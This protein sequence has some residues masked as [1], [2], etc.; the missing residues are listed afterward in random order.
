MISQIKRLVTLILLFSTFCSV[1]GQTYVLNGTTNGTTINTCG[2]TF[3]DSGINS[4]YSNNE[5]FSI[6]FCSNA[7]QSIELDFSSFDIENQ[8]SCS[9]DVLEIYD[10]LN[11]SSSLLGSYCGTSVP[12][13]IVST[14]DCLHVTFSSNASVNAAGWFANIICGNTD[15][16]CGN[17]IDDDGDGSIDEHCNSCPTGSISY[18]RWS[19]ITG[20][21]VSSLTNHP[22]YPNNPSHSG[23][24]SLFQGPNNI[25]NNFGTRVRG[26]LKPT[27]TGWYDFTVTSDDSSEFYIS[28]DGDPNNKVLVASVPGWTYVTEFDKYP[29]Q[30]SAAIYLYAGA[31]YYVEMLHKE[32]IGGDHLQVYWTTPSSSTNTIIPGSVLST[33]DC[34][35]PQQAVNLSLPQTQYF[36]DDS[37]PTLNGGSPA[38]GTYSG[39]GVTGN[40]LNLSTAGEGIH[41]ITYSYT[42][43]SGCEN[44]D[45]D[46]IEILDLTSYAYEVCNNGIDD[47]GDGSIDEDC[48]DCEAGSI[49]YE[50][51]LGISGVSISDLTSNA[52]YPNNPSESGVFTS[53]NGPIGYGGN[54]GTRVRGYLEPQETGYYTFT[55]TSDDRSELYLSSDGDPNN[56]SVIASVPGWSN[57]T[58][59]NKYP[60]Q[61]SAAIYLYAGAHY[62]IEMLH[63]E[64]GGGDHL[65]TYW[66]TPSNSTRTII[67]GSF[68]HP[69]E[70]CFIDAGSDATICLGSSVGLT[71]TPDGSGSFS[72]N[73]SPAAGLSSTSVQNPTASPTS[74]TIYTVTVTD[75]TGC[76]ATDE[77]E[78]TVLNGPIVTVPNENIC[79]GETSNITPTATGASPFTFDWGGATTSG[80]TLTVSPLITTIYTV[81]VT[82]NNSCTSTASTTINVEQLPNV[83]LNIPDLE[84]CIDDMNVT[85]SGGSPSGGTYSIDGVIGNILDVN[86][87]GL[88]VHTIGYTYT[89]GNGCTNSASQVININDVPSVELSLAINESCVDAS[90]IELS[91]GTPSGGIYSGPGVTGT[92]FDIST[93]GVGIHTI[94]YTYE[95]GNGC[96]DTATD[97]I[98][99]YDLPTVDLVFSTTEFCVSETTF[100]LSEGTPMGGSYNG[101][102]VIGSNFD[103]GLAGIGTHIIEYELTDGNGCINSASQ[104]IEVYGLP[105][106]TFDLGISE[107]CVN[108]MDINLTGGSP[109]GGTYSGPGVN[110]STFS[111]SVAGLGLHTLTYTYSD[112]NNCEETGTHQIFVND[113]TAV[114]LDLPINESCIE[115]SSIDL[116]DGMPSGGTYSGPGVTGTSFDI[117]TAGEGI[118]TIVYTYEDGNGCINT[119]TDQIEIYDLPSVE[120][121][122][123]NTDDCISESIFA[124]SGGTPIGGT[125]SGPGVTGTNFNASLAGLGTHTIQYEFID[126]NGCEDSAIQE[127][128]VHELPSVAFEI[129]QKEICLNSVSIEIS[130]GTP[131]GGTYSGTAVNGNLFSP[132]N[133]GLGT[134][135]ITYT[136][137]DAFGCQNSLDQ[138]IEV[139]N[140]P[141]VSM[142]IGKYT[143]CVDEDP[144]TLLGE[145]PSGGMYTGPG[146][147][148]NVFDPQSAG[149][150]IHTIRYE[151]TGTNNCINS[152]TEEI[153]VYDLPPVTL[154]FADPNLCVQSDMFELNEGTPSGGSYS[155]IGVNGTNFDASS[156]G[157]GTYEVTYSYSD[158]NGCVNQDSDF[159]VV[160]NTTDL[161]FELTNN[162]VCQEETA[163]ALTEASPTGGNYSGPGVTAN[164]FSPSDAGVGLHTIIYTYDDGSCINEISDEIEVLSTPTVTLDL[165]VIEACYGEDKITISGGFPSGGTY[166]GPGILGITLS[167]YD[168]GI[169]VHEFSYTYTNSDGCTGVATQL[170]TVHALPS[171][172]LNLS[173]DEACI[174]ETIHTLDGMSPAGGTF[175]GPGVTGTNFDASSVGVGSHEITYSYTDS[176]GCV[177]EATDIIVVSNPKELTFELTE[178]QICQ[179]ASAI[180]LSEANPA[181]GTYSGPGVIGNNFNPAD[182]GVGVHTITYTYDDGVCVSVITDEIEV[183]PTPLVTID[184]DINQAC[185]GE[186]NIILSGGLPAGGTYSGNGISD[187]SLNTFDSGA[188]TF[189]VTYTYTSPDGCMDSATQPFTVH[190]LPTVTLNL[191][192]DLACVTETVHMLDGMSPS[193]GTFSGPGV[194]GTNFDATIAGSGDHEIV[195]AYIDQFGC[196]NTATDII[197]VVDLPNPTLILPAETICEGEILSLSGGEPAGGEWTGPG[198]VGDEFDASI[199]G[200]GTHTINYTFTISECYIFA[201]DQI[202][203]YPLPTVTVSLSQTAFCF[204]ETFVLDG[205]SPLGGIWSGPGVVGGI[206]DSALA[207]VGTH[208]VVYSFTSNDGCSIETT[209]ELTVYQETVVDL[210][211]GQDVDCADNN[212]L[213]LSGGFPL[214]GV[215][216]GP[217]VSGNNFDASTAGE[218]IHSISYSFTDA[219]GCTN[220]AFDQ[221]TVNPLPDVTLDLLSDEACPDE[222]TV[223][224]SGGWPLGGTYSGPGVVGNT[225]D[226]GLAGEGVH[227]I[228]YTV[229]TN[230]CTD[231]ATDD[232]EV[233]PAYDE[234]FA[235]DVDGVCI[236]FD[237]ELS[238]NAPLGGLYSGPG[239]NPFNGDFLSVVAGIGTHTINYNFIDANGCEV[240]LSDELTV[241]D[242]PPASLSIENN[243]LCATEVNVA[244]TGGTP[245]GGTY[246]G[247]GVTGN[248]F[249][250]LSVGA[251]SYTITYSY[252]DSNGCQAEAIDE[253]VVDP[254]PS[255]TFTYTDDH[256]NLSSGSVSF[257]FQDQANISQIQFSLNGGTNW[258][259]PIS[260]ASGGITYA[261]LSAGTYNLMVRNEGGTCETDLGQIVIENIDGPTAD[262]GPDVTI[263]AFDNTQLTGAGGSFYIWSP[264]TGLNNTNISDPIASPT[265]TTTYTLQVTDIF[266]CTDTD[267]VTVFVETTCAGTITD[268]DYPYTESFESGLG[269]WS[270]ETQDDFDWL[271]NNGSIA[272]G[273]SASQ[274]TWYMMA[275]EDNTTSQTAIFRSPCFDLMDQS[276]AQ[277]TFDYYLANGGSLSLQATNEYGTNWTTIWS[278][279][280]N[281]GF[282]W[283]TQIVDLFAYLNT[284]LQLRFV[285]DMGSSSGGSMGVDNV[286]FITTGCGCDDT[287][288]PF[289]NFNLVSDPQPF[290]VDIDCDGDADMLSGG[291]EQLFFFENNG[292]GTYTDQTGTGQDIMPNLNFLDMTIGLVDLDNDGDKDMSIVGNEAFNKFFFWNTGTK[293]NPI[294]TQAGTGGTPANPIAGFDFSSLDG[295]VWI[296]YADPTIYWADL[297]NDDDYDAVVGGKLGWF[298][299]YENIGD[300]MTPNLVA[301]T[302]GANPFNGLRVDGADEGNGLIQYESSPFL[303]DWD[304]DGDLDLFS[305]NQI[306][307]VQYFENIGS[308]TNPIFVERSGSANPFDGVIFSEDS[309]LSIIDEDCDGDWDVFY[310]VGDSPADAE[311]TICD[312]LVAVPNFA[313]AS[314]NQSHFC[315]GESIFLSEESTVGVTWNWTGPDGFTSTEQNPVLNDAADEMVGTYTVTITNEQ[316]CEFTST[317]DIT[318]SGSTA[319]AGPDS[320][321]DQGESTQNQGSGDGNTYIWSPATGLDD[322][323]VLNPTANPT[324]TTTYTLTVIDQFGCASTDQMTVYVTSAACTYKNQLFFADFENTIGDNF[325]TIQNNATDG[326]FI[327]GEPSP[328]TQS[329]LTVMELNPQEGDQSMITGNATNYTQDLDGGPSTA[330]SSNFDLPN[331]AT[332]VTLEMYWYFSHFINGDAA[333]FLTIE[334]RDA[335]NN[336]VLQTLVDET[337]SP[338][339]RDAVWTLLNADLSSHAGKTVYLYVRASDAGNGSKVEVGIDNILVTGTFSTIADIELTQKDFCDTDSPYVLSGGT[340]EGGTYVGTG[341]TGNIFDP[342]AAGPGTHT[343]TYEYSDIGGCIAQAAAWIEVSEPPLTELELVID[344]VCVNQAAVGL[345]GGLPTG[346]EWSGTSVIGSTFYPPVAGVGAHDITYTVTDANGCSNS[347]TAEIYVL[348]VPIVKGISSTDAFCGLDNGTITIS[349]DDVV[350]IDSIE[351]SLDGGFTWQDAVADTDGDV[352]Y[353]DLPF[354]SYDLWVR[355]ANENCPSQM[356]LT[357]I[358][359]ILPPLV[360]VGTDLDFCVGDSRT[361]NP[362]V[363]AGTSP[364]TYS[365]SG[366]NGFASDQI[367]VEL[368]DEGVYALVVTDDNNCT[369]TDSLTISNFSLSIDA[370]IVPVACFGDDNGRILASA[371]G[372]PPYTYTLIGEG[373][374]GSGV[375][376]NLTQGFYTLQVQDGSG[377]VST[378]GFNVPG[379]PPLTCSQDSCVRNTSVSWSG[380]DNGPWTTSIGTTNVSLSVTNESNTTVSTFALDGSITNSNP[381]WFVESAAGTPALTITPNWDTAPED[382]MTDIDVATDDKGVMTFTFTFDNAISDIVLHV[383][384]LGEFA[385]NGTTTRSNSSQWTITT[386]GV[387]LYKLSGTADLEV[388]GNAFFRSYDVEHDMGADAAASTAEGSAAGSIAVFASTPLSSITFEVTGV[389]LEGQAQDE[390]LLAISGSEC[391]P[392]TPTNFNCDSAPGAATISAHGGVQP[393]TYQWENGETTQT[394]TNLSGGTHAVSITDANGCVQVCSVT[395]EEDIIDVSAGMNISFCAD[396]SGILTPNV[397]GGTGPY[398]YAW[399]GPNGFTYADENPTVTEGGAYD[400]IVTDN[401]GC[402]GMDQVIVYAFA[403]EETSNCYYL[404]EFNNFSYFGSDGTLDWSSFGWDET[405]DNNSAISGD[406]MISD[407]EGTL[408]MQNTNNTDPSIERQVDLGGHSSAILSFDYSTEGSLVGGDVFVVEVFDGTSWNTVFS[409]I[410][411]L[412]GVQKPWLDITD[413]ISADAAIR[414]SIES[415]YNQ[416]S[417]KLIIDNVRIDLDCLCEGNS[418]AGIDLEICAGDT[419]Q[420]MGIGDGDFVWS[421]A[422]TLSDATV[423]EPLAFPTETTTYQ[424][425]VTD[426]YGCEDTSEVTITVNESIAANITPETADYCYDGSGSALLDISEGTGP[427]SVSWTDEDGTPVGSLEVPNLGTVEILGLFGGVTYCFQILDANGCVVQSP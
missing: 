173:D 28:S 209:H 47:D 346:G 271:R 153:E 350:D 191:T 120:L 99:I 334:L 140:L 144:Y 420:L 275:D 93:A 122:L 290:S 244:L 300:E 250:P 257:V 145:T 5:N 422:T 385:T 278:E 51:W 246:S 85:L 80:N 331:L 160:S 174:T 342:V 248:V 183:F 45:T 407:S 20:T 410:G 239:V 98:E 367:S 228:T 25:A 336:S 401:N 76:I 107:V 318:I 265:V 180:T 105:V 384:K 199:A 21:L 177:G 59:F 35:A 67:A 72:F 389:G 187:N 104:E 3:Y 52:N 90:S 178:N 126:S 386:P 100:A 103:A 161:T 146:V 392:S 418:D 325:W 63:K 189:E 31:H 102:G 409:N 154:I 356:E 56:K 283:E 383:D 315:Y 231:S 219:N 151:F 217:G 91:G 86:A 241:Y 416:S 224:L 362:I 147:T 226:I 213:L 303:I 215:W 348:T 404:H 269:L 312:L 229:T 157:E 375:F 302:G 221:I 109:A 197:S 132:M 326:N 19:S 337:G 167:T 46:Q 55:V 240:A 377:C 372:T 252:Q 111:P 294:F 138:Q 169:G 216:S 43:A 57:V 242:V 17:N 343:I 360:D 188:G 381:T 27:E 424:L 124:L 207:G 279:S 253:I 305:G 68:L 351:F 391:N 363:E 379:P 128:V 194:S 406:I 285:A 172:A 78:V 130:G 352:T 423:A 79:D 139:L 54:Y 414:F 332:E 245:A 184:L 284:D 274:G 2:G 37:N 112:A 306:S 1:N 60:S 323:T 38:G 119:T 403:C 10:G 289:E 131:I 96:T 4:N 307:T 249:N 149:P 340:P 419:I 329:G 369:T 62:Y 262:A 232:F 195:Y 291:D 16:I 310:G 314:A 415:G 164:S 394:A 388:S 117:L 222:D 397:S 322:P 400:L 324:A 9:N 74:T 36:I 301:R 7:G 393:Y 66:T 292:D 251:G 192:D 129:N 396:E 255:V 41:T 156:V 282:T 143:F 425:V 193:G 150:G 141:D 330:R 8:G 23:E 361:I 313:Q 320:T 166:S 11:T 208:D 179:E 185:F 408:H 81:T 345:F 390:L 254:T 380:V 108:S 234:P 298:L 136:Y 230:G 296:G 258:R 61:E 137:T 364:F 402:S 196:E 50:R 259:P 24:F 75:G 42:D 65:H 256:C 205:A 33:L 387:D 170:F 89:D 118:H 365:W 261:N 6:T 233:F 220:E 83:T 211:L 395:I 82:D 87:A 95:D 13:N 427:F 263:S 158:T 368:S 354:G 40:T 92:S 355:N 295:S 114:S 18:E 366:P 358:E 316:G 134:H 210:T 14:N 26:F 281:Q 353:T 101:P 413:Y 64:G 317:I 339:D 155:G 121:D 186:N 29:E 148:G 135:I 288:S 293:T 125:Y 338:T 225:I 162:I 347:I 44:I 69:L 417:K 212:T 273:P 266:G 243:N 94:T 202:V 321:I 218:G 113:V 84:Y 165:N 349:F 378:Q 73:W 304:G 272:G 190:D 200:P 15:E 270:Q 238:S 382:A 106:V 264:S 373:T 88:G 374:N 175:S 370:D 280:G 308:P 182:A 159:I 327:I 49:S 319:D 357:E 152:V 309:H 268:G 39:N 12:T 223:I 277:F 133:A 236:G 48:S 398:I 311:I 227:T 181:G 412:T 359:N 168:S 214:G 34:C 335:S 163:F 204:G 421:P 260:D 77:V 127:I 142:N 53:F 276:C 299:Y 58:E 110:G 411:A 116:S 198:V 203:V 22:N 30:E 237:I 286:E 123:P 328:Y 333:D 267:E 171:V 115:A 426:I 97:Q 70:C 287:S 376:N 206:F 235:L 371:N 405:G 341:V 176:N 247:I 344:T 71:S 32:G 297:D 201:S 399:S